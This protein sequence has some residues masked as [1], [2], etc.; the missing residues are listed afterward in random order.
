MYQQI[1]ASAKQEVQPENNF[2]GQ[3]RVFADIIDIEAFP[4]IKHPKEK[5]QCK[6]EE[7]TQWREPGVKC[8]YRR[9][10]KIKMKKYF[11]YLKD[12]M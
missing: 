2:S 6:Q 5:K 1:E 3:K 9:T 11:R 8:K 12:Q 4:K 7:I 10:K